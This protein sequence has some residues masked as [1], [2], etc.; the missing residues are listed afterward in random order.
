MKT[1]DTSNQVYH[2]IVPYSIPGAHK[3]VRSKQ[4]KMGDFK[5]NLFAGRLPYVVSR[6]SSHFWNTLYGSS[7]DIKIKK[8]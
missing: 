1:H 6:D 7:T 3:K 4:K 2:K 8:S 5:N